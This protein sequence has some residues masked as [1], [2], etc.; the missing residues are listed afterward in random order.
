MNFTFNNDAT[1]EENFKALAD[2]ATEDIDALKAQ[3]ESLTEDAIAA[4]QKADQ[5][6][7]DLAAALE[8]IDEIEADSGD[9]AQSESDQPDG[10]AAD[11]ALAPLLTAMNAISGKVDAMNG[12]FDAL[13]EEAKTGAAA[14]GK[15]KAAGG[16][17]SAAGS[18]ASD[19]SGEGS[20]KQSYE[21]VFAKDAEINPLGRTL[22]AVLSDSDLGS[23][24]M[25]A[26]FQAKH[27]TPDQFKAAQ[28]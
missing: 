23:V 9:E 12:R 8:R 19:G 21:D 22:D 11:K 24:Q 15:T 6:E 2:A 28:Q 10:E 18:E 4:T 13:E 25:L 14:L 7:T 3:N 1:L 27:G 26:A 5:A 20:A 16:E 17:D